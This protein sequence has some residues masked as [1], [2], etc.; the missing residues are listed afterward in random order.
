MGPLLG[1]RVTP[2]NPTFCY[3]QRLLRYTPLQRQLSFWGT[4]ITHPRPLSTDSSDFPESL[5]RVTI[6]F[7]RNT[8]LCEP[9]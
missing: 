2:P 4:P 8:S 7:I 3:A 1:Q 6:F 5:L 9:L